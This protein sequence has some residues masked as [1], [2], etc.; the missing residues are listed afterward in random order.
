[1][2]PET[3]REREPPTW[4]GSLE[5]LLDVGDE[6]AVDVGV[7]DSSRLEWTAVV[8]PSTSRRYRLA[9]ELDVPANLFPPHVPWAQ[10]QSF[11]RFERP[12]ANCDHTDAVS[13]LREE[14]LV[15]TS[16]LA[17]ASQGFWRHVRRVLAEPGG[18]DEDE[19][20]ALLVWLHAGLYS[21]ERARATLAA[22]TDAATERERGFVDE[23]LST[24]LSAM[25]AGMARAL[26]D[27]H[28]AAEVPAERVAL[29][30]G[31]EARIVDAL[32]AEAEHRRAR[33]YVSIEDPSARGLE[34]Y[35]E[36]TGVLKKRFQALLYLQRV[37]QPMEERVRPWVAALSAATAGAI[38]FTLQL[39][40]GASR[41]SAG[42]Q[43]GRGLALLLIV[44]ALAY[45][46]KERLQIAGVHW[47]AR[48]LGR[49]YARRSARFSTATRAL[50]LTA[51]ESFA[52]Q[53]FEAAD[54]DGPN[55][56]PTVRLRFV[57]D[58]RLRPAAAQGQLRLIFRY[59]LSPLFA[60]L[61]DPVKTV[62]VVDRAARAL[63]DR[64]RAAHLSDP[65]PR[66]AG[67]GRRGARAGGVAGDGQVRAASGGAGRRRVS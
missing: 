26:V 27:V 43:V 49:L 56:T 54:V 3:T 60:R 25:L 50:V 23:Y 62:G 24:Q 55:A 14:A 61:H 38:A 58:G 16:R 67:V 59:D 37:S 30:R 6:L 9:V 29:V 19:R 57:H 8:P 51:R 45:G 17:A 28:A 36:R 12:H 35:V 15:T 7:H 53:A 66:H 18:S 32:L 63:R 4:S 5:E 20:A 21:V 13:R 52:E 2:T 40:F 47:L 11:A 10:L 48:G 44:V 42:Q 41:A 31:I 33:G 22:E 34:R 39:Y 1:M 46:L 64:R 65:G